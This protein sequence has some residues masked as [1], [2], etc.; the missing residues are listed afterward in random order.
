MNKFTLYRF[1]APF[2]SRLQSRLRTERIDVDVDGFAG[3]IGEGERKAEVAEL[4]WEILQEEAFVRDFRPGPDDNLSGVYGMGPEDVRDD[5]IAPLLDRLGLSVQGIDFTGF[6]FS[7]IVNPRDAGR[8]VM[9]IA[10]AQNRH[11]G[12]RFTD[13]E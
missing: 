7:S 13:L 6:D 11:G 4:L 3:G 8:F 1:L 9:R 2:R 12:R 5:V 10:A